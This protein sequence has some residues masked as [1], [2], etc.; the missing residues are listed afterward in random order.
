VQVAQSRLGGQDRT[1]AA[2][3]APAALLGFLKSLLPKDPPG[4][5]RSGGPFRDR[6]YMGSRRARRVLAADQSDYSPDPKTDFAR[7]PPNANAP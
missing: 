4:I 6:E 5:G 3:P 1:A 2:K 7:Y